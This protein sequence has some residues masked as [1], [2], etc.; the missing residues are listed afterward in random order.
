LK[1]DDYLLNDY[2][3]G[4]RPP[5]NLYVAY[6]ASQRKGQSAHSP[7]SC[8]PGGGWKLTEFAQRELPFTTLAGEP[9]RVNRALIELGTNRQVVYYWFQQRGRIVT[10]EYLVKWYI[11]WDALTRNRSDGALVRL[12]APVLPG[13]S[14]EDADEELIQFT[15]AA[16]AKIA[17]YVP[18]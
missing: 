10:N 2:A 14:V 11:F 16:L 17:A 8:L 5:V 12:T 18:D 7:R 13:Q 3:R 15:G 9:M 1:L 4:L 6:Y